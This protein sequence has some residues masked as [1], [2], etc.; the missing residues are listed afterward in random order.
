[1]GYGTN[2][3]GSSLLTLQSHLYTKSEI[4][5]ADQ[6][7]KCGTTVDGE[8]IKGQTRRLSGEE[9]T[10]QLGKYHHALR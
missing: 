1:M 3:G 7:S 10:V 2:H 4:S 5:I 8:L 6:D 9:H